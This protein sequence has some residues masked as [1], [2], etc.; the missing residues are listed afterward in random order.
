MNDTHVF[1]SLV[2]THILVSDYY[3]CN[4]KL[5]VVISYKMMTI[6]NYRGQNVKKMLED[7]MFMAITVA[8]GQVTR[9]Y[10]HCQYSPKTFFVISRKCSE[11]I[12]LFINSSLVFKLC[13]K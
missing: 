1:N 5:A 11:N 3:L 10:L 2:I 6:S 7:K 9:E 13:G 8:R 12:L 4:S